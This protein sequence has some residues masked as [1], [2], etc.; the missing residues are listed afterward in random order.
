MQSNHQP[1]SNAAIAG[2]AVLL[3]FLLLF[4]IS[5]PFEYSAQSTRPVLTV[6]GLMIFA[7]TLAFVGLGFAC[8][9]STF[10][11]KKLLMVIFGLAL[12]IRLVA[13]F[14]TPILE[15]DYYR[16]IWDGKVVCEGVSPYRFS[17]AQVLK[18]GIAPGKHLEQVSQLATRSESNFVALN[19]I[20]YEKYTT[21]YPPVSQ[22]VFAAVMKLTPESASI[23][24]HVIVMKI[25]MLLFDLGTILLLAG[26]LKMARIHLGWLIAYAW[27]PLVIKEIAN[28]G[29]LDAIATF[30]VVLTLY[31]VVKQNLL[32]HVKSQRWW[33][34]LAGVTL[35]LAVGAKLYPLVIFPA[36]VVAVSA[37]GC[38]AVKRLMGG[39]VFSF[40]FVL[41]S[42]LVLVPMFNKHGD[43]EVSRVSQTA[44]Q[45]MLEGS[46]LAAKSDPGKSRDGF[47]GFFSSWRMN[48]PIFST[49]YFNLKS[50]TNESIQ[51]WF[52]VTSKPWR[53]R[54]NQWFRS[55]GVDGNDPAHL[56][57]RALTL[58]LFSC[59]YLFQ[60]V[61]LYNS[62]DRETQWVIHLVRRI[63]LILAI[64]LVLQPT[65]NPWYFVWVAPLTCMTN[66]RGWLLASGFLML[67]YTRFWF[68]SL[69]RTF[70]FGGQSFD[71]VSLFDHCFVFVEFGL[72]FAVLIF[73]Q[74]RKRDETSDLQ[75]AA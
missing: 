18:P 24:T 59:F 4:L 29:H 69:T 5:A 23:E 57:A 72:I 37:K 55:F 52:V 47:G 3:V 43:D 62:E 71:G 63:T 38:E 30:F 7:A 8:Q 60:L 26:L 66:N 41:T 31:L 14:T 48:D 19:R 40:A 21:L 15:I 2:L 32:S 68:K 42:C 1:L 74:T 54:L 46:S 49:V 65:V 9:V 50:D 16:Y 56:I 12:S 36:L 34:V 51:P 44:S 45:T 70:A 58:S 39:A 11:Y 35:G 25:A 73:F 6:V 17:P 67:Y 33:L 13:L 61:K 75:N 64:F 53:G 10:Q 22:F 27:N 20:H 28:S